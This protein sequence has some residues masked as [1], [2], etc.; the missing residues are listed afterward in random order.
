MTPGEADRRIVLSR[1]TLGKFRQGLVSIN[2]VSLITGEI[3]LLEG[4]AQS[5]P[6]KANKLAR[7][8]ND[9]REYLDRVRT[10]H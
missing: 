2:N 6:S 10:V 4:I 8:V 5:H 1:H 9:W 3:A 7:L